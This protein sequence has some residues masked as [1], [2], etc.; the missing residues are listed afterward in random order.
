MRLIGNFTQAPSSSTFIGKDVIKTSTTKE[1]KLE[2]FVD[3]GTL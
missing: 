1:L 3:K 2:V